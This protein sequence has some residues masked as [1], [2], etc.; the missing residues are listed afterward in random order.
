MNTMT[1]T[2]ER[3]V[4]SLFD[5]N[6]PKIMGVFRPEYAKKGFTLRVGDNDVGEYVRLGTAIRTPKQDTALAHVKFYDRLVRELAALPQNI[7]NT[8]TLRAHASEGHPLGIG[9]GRTRDASPEV[10]RHSVWLHLSQM[11]D[12]YDTKVTRV[13]YDG[14]RRHVLA[15]PFM[16]DLERA[17][18]QQYEMARMFHYMHLGLSPHYAPDLK[19]PQALPPA[20]SPVWTATTKAYNTGT[21]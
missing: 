2:I 17:E 13:E 3:R 19:K 15:M 8:L 5:A 16:A 21:E 20:S 18:T 9:I 7:R 14:E 11:F 12:T 4:S 6:L 10:A 1:D